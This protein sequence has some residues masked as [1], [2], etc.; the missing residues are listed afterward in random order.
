MPHQITIKPSEHSFACDDGETVLAAAMRADLM[1][2]YGCRNGACG[3]CKTRLLEGVV[4]YGH[5]QPGTLTDTEKRQGYVLLCVARPQTDLV[6]EVREVRHLVADEP[7]GR[8]GREL[9][10][11]VAHPREDAVEGAML[12]GQVLQNLR[13]R[14][15]AAHNPSWRAASSFMISSAPPPIALTFTSR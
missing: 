5:F 9:P 3:T 12:G 7:A 10:L 11:R 6:V 8:V 4:D 14:R 15:H 13:Q 1:I 2:P